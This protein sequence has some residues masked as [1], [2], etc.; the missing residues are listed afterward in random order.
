MRIFMLDGLIIGVAG[1]LLG[2][3]LGYSICW[4]I[5]T[6]YTFPTEV[7]YISRIPVDIRTFDVLVVGL[8]AV[9]ISLLATIYPSRQAA[10]LDPAVALRYE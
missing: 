8:S 10:K 4:G 7:Y 9:F 2:I 1:I 5:Q 3:P 6:F